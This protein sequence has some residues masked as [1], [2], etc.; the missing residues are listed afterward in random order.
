[1]S[2]PRNSNIAL[3]YLYYPQAPCVMPTSYAG[4]VY[5][6]DYFSTPFLS[7]GSGGDIGEY[8]PPTTGRSNRKYYKEGTTRYAHPQRWEGLGSMSCEGEEMSLTKEQAI[9]YSNQNG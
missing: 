7:I 2:R 3:G 5:F 1:V 9:E 4:R 6:A 8:L